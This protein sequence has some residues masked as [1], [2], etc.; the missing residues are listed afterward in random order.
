MATSSHGHREGV[1]RIEAIR[2]LKHRSG[3]LLLSMGIRG[4]VVVRVER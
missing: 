4:W 3:E 2:K 1:R